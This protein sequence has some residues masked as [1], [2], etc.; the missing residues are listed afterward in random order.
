MAGELSPLQSHTSWH[1]TGV[2]A[3]LRLETLK[4]FNILQLPTQKNP[5]I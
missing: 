5:R 1:E 2:R 3:A 4:N